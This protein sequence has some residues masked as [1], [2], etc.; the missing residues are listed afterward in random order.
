[1]KITPLKKLVFCASLLDLSV[2]SIY[3]THDIL[4]TS[5]TSMFRRSLSIN[6]RRISSAFP[7]DSSTAWKS[8]SI[9][10]KRSY[11]DFN[12]ND[13]EGSLQS[14][15]NVRDNTSW[16]PDSAV[17]Q[18][19]LDKI[20]LCET[21]LSQSGRYLQETKDLFKSLKG[22]YNS[23]LS[24]SFG[25]T[26]LEHN[27][28]QQSSARAPSN[29]PSQQMQNKR[30]AV[31][32]PVNQNNS[33]GAARTQNGSAG[34]FPAHE[35][36]SLK[37]SGSNGSFEND[38]TVNEEN[39]NQD[40]AKK[41]RL[42]QEDFE[43]RIIR[44]CKSPQM[45]NRDDLRRLLDLYGA[46]ANKVKDGITKVLNGQIDTPK[47][48]LFRAVSEHVQSKKSNIS[49]Y[50]AMYG[51][52]CQAFDQDVM[53]VVYRVLHTMM[54]ENAQMLT[55][56]NSKNN[57]NWSKQD[58]VSFI[59]LGA[60]PLY[61]LTTNEVKLIM[62]LYAVNSNIPKDAI[63]KVLSGDTDSSK[64][65]IYR[66]VLAHAKSME[67][68]EVYRNIY[69][70]LIKSLNEQ[71]MPI[72][73]RMI[74]NDLHNKGETHDNAN[75]M[76]KVIPARSNNILEDPMDSHDQ[77]PNNDYGTD[78]PIFNQN[79]H[80]SRNNQRPV[81]NPE[82]VIQSRDGKYTITKKEQAR[83]SR[84]Y[85]L[86]PELDG[87][88]IAWLLSGRSNRMDSP[89]G[90]AL[91]AAIEQI[92]QEA[93]QEGDYTPIDINYFRKLYWASLRVTGS[94]GVKAIRG[95]FRAEQPNTQ[96]SELN[97]YLTSLESEMAEKKKSPH[98]KSK[99][100]VTKALAKKK[101]NEKKSKLK[102]NKK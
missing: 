75:L 63:S 98:P 88:S 71:A 44:A 25:T 3:A 33:N 70:R 85:A 53:V 66:A 49:V 65:A 92:S 21:F 32:I 93:V 47:S 40:L 28:R 87:R 102:G 18:D 80:I 39:I 43:N 37:Y 58:Y 10:V 7:N 96:D 74:K 45:V 9:I 61:P 54:K 14:L 76:S 97:E 34:A 64:S 86:L 83:L 15:S 62:D 48:S 42:I 101:E 100:S 79:N 78:T 30:T 52:L 56:M 36:D 11:S 82:E 16:S 13:D 8:S 55:H 89:S 77:S 2:Q 29:E 31:I 51:R 59:V 57:E 68:L 6:L 35:K 84:I 81:N 38:V 22:G 1:M 90:Q 46:L 19:I 50:R 69:S 17:V 24:Y 26:T 95:K 20:L 60:N 27:N 12:H 94:T 91:N 41:V 4:I 99:I 23:D 72:I 5:A 73:Y 67:N